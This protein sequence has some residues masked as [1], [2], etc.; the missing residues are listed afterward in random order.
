MLQ[1]I[2]LEKLKP[3]EVNLKHMK[4]RDMRKY[5]SSVDLTSM[6]M[7]LLYKAHLL[8]EQIEEHQCTK[9]NYN[10]IL[11]ESNNL[12]KKAYLISN[13]LNKNPIYWN[14]EDIEHDFVN[15]MLLDVEKC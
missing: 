8:F 2:P 4:K 15:M 12:T 13:L 10:Q 7:D 3:L 11:I 1:L 14:D 5:Y 9:E 6:S